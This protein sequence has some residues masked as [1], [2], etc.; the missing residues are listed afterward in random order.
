MKMNGQLFLDKHEGNLILSASVST[1]FRCLP[2]CP[3]PLDQKTN[4][5]RYTHTLQISTLFQDHLLFHCLIT[6]P[7]RK[8]GVKN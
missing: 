2:S 8:T 3:P 5:N 6:I 1:E 7:T 4:P